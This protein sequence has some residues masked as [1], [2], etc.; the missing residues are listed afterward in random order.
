MFAIFPNL[1]DD[2]CLPLS[3]AL[4]DDTSPHL[5]LAASGVVLP[6]A[7]SLKGNSTQ[8]LLSCVQSLPQS[9]FKISGI[10]G[11]LKSDRLIHGTSDISEEVLTLLKS[12]IFHSDSVIRLEAFG[13]LCI[14]KK[15][16]DG[17]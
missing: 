16:F 9:R 15:V 12:A 11:I 7:L 14:S 3:S 17:I 8:K 1:Q 5:R 4:I 13:Y 10:L 6:A 2:W